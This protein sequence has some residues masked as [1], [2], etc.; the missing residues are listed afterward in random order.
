MICNV[1]INLLLI[2]WYWYIDID[3]SILLSKNQVGQHMRK[4]RYI[5][6]FIVY[7][8]KY[9]IQQIKTVLHVHIYFKC[10]SFY[11]LSNIFG[12]NRII[13]SLLEKSTSVL[14]EYM[15]SRLYCKYLSHICYALGYLFEKKIQ[16]DGSDKYVKF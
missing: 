8:T 5:L 16:S 14:S 15:C 4:K 10:T 9:K 2:F 11:H 13:V 1:Y 3:T 6:S 7:Y 12:R